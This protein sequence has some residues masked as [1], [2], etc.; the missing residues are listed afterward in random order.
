MEIEITITKKVEIADIYLHRIGEITEDGSIGSFDEAVEY[1]MKLRAEF[2]RDTARAIVKYVDMERRD[3][4]S[5]ELAC[6]LVKAVK[7]EPV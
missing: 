7:S 5:K 3:T 6:A 4:L 1:V 2:D